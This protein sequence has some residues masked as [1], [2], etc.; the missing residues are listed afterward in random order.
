[1]LLLIAGAVGLRFRTLQL[2][3]ATQVGQLTDLMPEET[4]VGLRLLPS[5]ASAQQPLWETV[6]NRLDWLQSLPPSLRR[7]LEGMGT[8]ETARGDRQL[9]LLWLDATTARLPGVPRPTEPALVIPLSSAQPIE[10][11]LSEL[12]QQGQ[13]TERQRARRSWLG[14]LKNGYSLALLDQ[15]YLAIAPS[16]APLAA[17]LRAYRGRN[18]LANN[19]YYQ[20]SCLDFPADRRAELYL[21]WPRAQ[22]AAIAQGQPFPL[23]PLVQR[24]CAGMTPTP[25][26]LQLIGKAWP[27][28]AS[29]SNPET[30]EDLL[31][32]ASAQT[33]L[34]L[35]SHNLALAWQGLSQDNRLLNWPQLLSLPRDFQAL[36]GTDLQKDW[37]NGLT[38]SYAVSLVP[39]TG[40]PRFR[41]SLLFLVQTNNRRQ[42]DD[43]LQRLE[44]RLTHGGRLRLKRE[45]EIVRWLN[46][47]GEILASSGWLGNDPT[48]T[49]AANHTLFFG[50]GTTTPQAASAGER[51]PLAA[52]GNPQKDT[53]VHFNLVQLRQLQLLPNLGPLTTWVQPF[54]QTELSVSPSQNQIAAFRLALTTPPKRP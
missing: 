14:Q 5:N 46:P 22:S 35:S 27:V 15:R 50:I 38:G 10:A 25:T 28:A 34:W 45:G 17:I 6:L 39:N 3:T 48:G 7:Q 43:S 33:L 20:R 2:P 1:L 32:Y 42:I 11:T 37:L 29:R 30:N 23:P 18:R 53:L 41:A 47:Q 54:S 21:D 16:D 26:G 12:R 52:L 49:G 19:L 51:L 13:L 44:Q 40:D 31:T 36:T 8:A 4:V 9:L 24:L